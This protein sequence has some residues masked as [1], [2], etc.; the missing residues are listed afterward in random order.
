MSFVKLT[1][2][3]A[4]EEDIW[5]EVCKI[6]GISPYALNEGMDPQFEVYIPLNEYIRMRRDNEKVKDLRQYKKNVLKRASYQ[7]E[8]LWRGFNIEKE[9]T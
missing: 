8:L 7:E 4:M 5:E 1:L 2:E 3:K 9:R 6:T